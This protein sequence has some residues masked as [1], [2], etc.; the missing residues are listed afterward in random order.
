MVVLS[1]AAALVVVGVVAAS[2]W[3]T[4][5]SLFEDHGASFGARPVSVARAALTVAVTFP[6]DEGGPRVVDF[7]GARAR[8]GTDTARSQTTFAICSP[9]GTGDIIGAVRGDLDEWCRDVR[10]LAGDRM[11]LTSGRGSDYVV[12]TIRP[13]RPG[14]TRIEG[15]D[16]DYSLGRDGWYRRGRDTVAV[17]FTVRAR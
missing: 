15:V 2:R 1:V 3:W 4:H 11:T 9:H 17:D 10:P 7:R 6:S 8:L 14:R 13:T 12:L 16:L 5:P